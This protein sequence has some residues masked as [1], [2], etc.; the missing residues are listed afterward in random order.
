[1]N[2]TPE[3]T[4]IAKKVL[5]VWGTAL[6]GRRTMSVEKAV[7]ITKLVLR[8]S[9]RDVRP[10]RPLTDLERIALDT[11]L[12]C[13]IRAR[14]HIAA[15]LPGHPASS[16]LATLGLLSAALDAGRLTITE[17]TQ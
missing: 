4:A 16:S 9:G 2:I 14:E 8:E 5:D 1:M 6:N 15:T 12:T 17:V 3:T 10:S 7:G 11:A 13:A